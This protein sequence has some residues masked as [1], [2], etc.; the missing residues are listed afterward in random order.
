MAPATNTTYPPSPSLATPSPPNASESIVSS[1]SSPRC[2]RT[3]AAAES[4]ARSA[5]TPA[6]RSTAAGGGSVGVLSLIVDFVRVCIYAGGH[7]KYDGAPSRQN[8]RYHPT[9]LDSRGGPDDSRAAVP[10][11]EEHTSEL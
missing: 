11:S 6:A 10:R 7:C 5:G 3:A 9:P 2:G 8:K 1:S 4:A